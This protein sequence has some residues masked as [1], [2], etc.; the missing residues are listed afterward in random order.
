VPT[1]LETNANRTYNA[2]HKFRDLYMLESLANDSVRTALNEKNLA[3]NACDSI[4][5]NH[6]K[7]E[8]NNALEINSLEKKIAS[9]DRWIR[10]WEGA[11][12]VLATTVWVMS[13]SK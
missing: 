12:L 7:I 5:A 1:S 11:T 4:N 13:F 10:V 2:A 9:K 6:G 8:A 3:L